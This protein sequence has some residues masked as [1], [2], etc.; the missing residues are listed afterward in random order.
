M[1][2]ATIVKKANPIAISALRGFETCDRKT[3]EPQGPRLAASKSW[4]SASLRGPSVKCC[5]FNWLMHDAAGT[6]S[7]TLLMVVRTAMRELGWIG[8]GHSRRAV[9]SMAKSSA[10]KPDVAPMP[11]TIAMISHHHHHHDCQSM[12]I[13]EGVLFGGLISW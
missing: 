12:I 5:H 7:A 2:S 4:R 1:P 10:I 8:R 9:L 11:I 3:N 13:S 6:I